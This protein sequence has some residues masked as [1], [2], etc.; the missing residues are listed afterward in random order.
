MKL[1]RLLETLNK[2]DPEKEIAV[3][4]A[5]SINGWVNGIDGFSIDENNRIILWGAEETLDEDEVDLG[6]FSKIL[7]SV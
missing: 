6:K 7:P 3:A 1:K 2:L 5:P 4:G